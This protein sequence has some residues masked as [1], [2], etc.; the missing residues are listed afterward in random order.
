M[1]GETQGSFSQDC[2]VA[3][4]VHGA[5]GGR[6]TVSDGSRRKTST[7]GGGR[8]VAGEARC[9]GHKVRPS[10]RRH[11]HPS[12]VWNRPQWPRVVRRARRYCGD[13]NACLGRLH[14]DA[15]RCLVVKSDLLGDSSVSQ[16]LGGTVHRQRRV[17]GDGEKRRHAIGLPARICS[18]NRRDEPDSRRVRVIAST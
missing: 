12:P 5:R 6:D 7:A 15:V 10:Q 14:S 9:C 17:N 2:G 11:G 18:L 1:S 3:K 16:P 8:S 4:G 13:K